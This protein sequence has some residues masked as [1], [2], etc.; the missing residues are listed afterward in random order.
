MKNPTILIAEEEHSINIVGYD[1]NKFVF[2]DPD[3]NESNRFGDGFGFLCCN[4]TLKRFTI[5]QRC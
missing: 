3:T 5:A 1:G 2:W 4:S